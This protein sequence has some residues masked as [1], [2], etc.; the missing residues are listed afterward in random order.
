MGNNLRKV[1]DA[2]VELGNVIPRIIKA[3]EAKQGFKSL[4]H[5]RDLLDEGFA[6][7]SVDFSLVDDEYKASRAEDHAALKDYLRVKFDIEDDRAEA[8]IEEISAAIVSLDPMVTD[9]IDAVKALQ[10]K[11]ALEVSNASGE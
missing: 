5:L 11:P 10:E 7:L 6:L 1:V 2:I 9:I 3:V 4:G 8:F